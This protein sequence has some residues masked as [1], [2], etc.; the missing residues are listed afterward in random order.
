LGCGNSPVTLFY[1]D[2]I[3][4]ATIKRHI[5]AIVVETGQLFWKTEI[6]G[7]TGISMVLMKNVLICGAG[8]TLRMFDGSD[9]KSVGNV[10]SLK[11]GYTL[12]N[13]LYFQDRLYAGSGGIVSCYDPNDFSLMWKNTLKGYGITHGITLV[14]YIN[15][16]SQD[17]CILVGMHGYIICLKADTGDILWH[18]SLKH[19]HHF[20]VSVCVHNNRVIVGSFGK[21]FVLNGDDGY[22][23]GKNSLSGYGYAEL[24]IANDQY[25]MNQSSSNLILYR[26][27]LDEQEGKK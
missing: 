15:S 6:S 11:S 3:V 20:F 9:G 21:L 14:P 23:V 8:G 5:F 26:N 13:Q 4:Y 17:P 2:G 25:N 24:C 27:I 22:L 12:V 16:T 7:Y 1:H 10:V 18:Y 19:T